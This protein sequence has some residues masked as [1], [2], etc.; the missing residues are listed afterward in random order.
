MRGL[1][2]YDEGR[3]LRPFLM[4]VMRDGLVDEVHRLRSLDRFAPNGVVFVEEKFLEMHVSN[5][6]CVSLE[7]DESVGW[8]ER[9]RKGLLDVVQ[10]RKVR[11]VYWALARPT[12]ESLVASRNVSGRVMR[13]PSVRAVAEELGYSARE[14]ERAITALRRAGGRRSK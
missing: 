4:G 11:A 6:G 12:A 9:G 5:E 10:S 14:V 2:R 13:R 1:V 3:A 7:I 8:C